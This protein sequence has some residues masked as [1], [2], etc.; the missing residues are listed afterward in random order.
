MVLDLEL[1]GTRVNSEN[2]AIPIDST[3][4]IR[5][6]SLDGDEWSAL[7]EA[8]FLTGTPAT[9]NS[10]VVSELHYNPGGADADLSEFIELAN[11]SGTLVDLAGVA[12]TQ[13]IDFTFDDSATLAP[14]GRLILV[15]DR[16]A[17]EA[18][19]GPVSQSPA[20][21]PGASPTTANA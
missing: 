4:T 10:L 5:A 21:T 11:I 14:G 17:F 18:T 20:A 3:T 9:A 16:D 19:H 12:F 2:A 15:A 8:T 7:S 13:G 6:R 1:G